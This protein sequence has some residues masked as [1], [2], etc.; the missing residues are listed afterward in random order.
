MYS[1]VCCSGRALVLP[2]QP[3]AFLTFLLLL[4]LWHLKLLILLWLIVGNLVVQVSQLK[5]M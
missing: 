3:I 2:S 4:S 1:K 5:Q